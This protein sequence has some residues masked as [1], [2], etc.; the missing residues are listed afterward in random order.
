MG[1]FWRYRAIWFAD[2]KDVAHT[3]SGELWYEILMIIGGSTA[4]IVTTLAST[5]K[6]CP[7]AFDSPR[8]GI[9]YMRTT[10]VRKFLSQQHF[11]TKTQLS[12]DSSSKP[13]GSCDMDSSQEGSQTTKP[14]M[15]V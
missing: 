14:L 9:Y 6:T 3:G 13:P 4:R 12:S 15:Q 11:Q 2:T 5:L 7:I 1:A 8:L 10:V